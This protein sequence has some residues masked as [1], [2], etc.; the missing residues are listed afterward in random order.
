MGAAP[1]VGPDARRA[2]DGSRTT[3]SAVCPAIGRACPSSKSAAVTM[4][5]REI[6]PSFMSVFEV[7]RLVVAVKFH[8]RR[9]LFLGAEARILRAAE[10]KLILY[11]RAGQVH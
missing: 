3:S 9:T 2:S 4:P 1:D 5:L 8:R 7:H 10:G 6:C 11:A